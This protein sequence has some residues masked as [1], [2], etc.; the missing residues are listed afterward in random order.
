MAITVYQTKIKIAIYR[1][2]GMVMLVVV[3]LVSPGS[4]DSTLSLH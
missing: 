2:W 3:V 1:L 4:V